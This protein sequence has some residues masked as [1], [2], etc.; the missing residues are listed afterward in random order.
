MASNHIV[1]RVNDI[2]KLLTQRSQPS[3]TKRSNLC[4]SRRRSK[5]LHRTQ[6][7]F[8]F[9]SSNRHFAGRWNSFCISVCLV[10]HK[11]LLKK[12][13]NDFNII[14]WCILLIFLI[15]VD[16]VD[17][18]FSILVPLISKGDKKTNKKI[19]F[20][21]TKL[22][23]L[24][25]HVVKYLIKA[26]LNMPEGTYTCLDVRVAETNNV[27]HYRIELS[28]RDEWTEIGEKARFKYTVIWLR[29]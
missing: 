26:Q 17:S 12:A 3:L 27:G 20:H 8:T 19:P 28:S 23:F 6:L 1:P 29:T 18:I 21:L 9:L 5:L 16:N 14:S 13:N 15:T 24:S 11:S 10:S 25:F 4:T 22:L 7:S 2:I